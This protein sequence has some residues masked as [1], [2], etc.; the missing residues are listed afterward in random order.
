MQALASEADCA[1]DVVKLVAKVARQTNLLALNVSIEAARAGV[2]G[3]GFAVVADEVKSLAAQT[4][5]AVEE[6]GS[7]LNKVKAGAHEAAAASLKIGATTGALSSIA[8]SIANAFESRDTPPS[9]W[10]TT[11][12]RPPSARGR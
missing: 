11:W 4:A 7:R 9:T 5:K 1:D 3:R 2:S 10:R 8:S 12:R 6:I